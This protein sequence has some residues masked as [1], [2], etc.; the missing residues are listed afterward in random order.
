MYEHLFLLSFG[1]ANE[2]DFK[3]VIPVMEEVSINYRNKNH[4]N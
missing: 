3:K 1:A 4:R 2:E